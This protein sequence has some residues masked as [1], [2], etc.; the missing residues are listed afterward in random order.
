MVNSDQE[1]TQTDRFS[2]RLHLVD[3]VAGEDPGLAKLETLTLEP[4]VNAHLAHRVELPL[5]K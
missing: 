2:A 4:T 1:K 5:L 3:M